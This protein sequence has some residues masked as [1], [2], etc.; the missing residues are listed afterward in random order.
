MTTYTTRQGR[1]GIY[2]TFR[3]TWVDPT[4]GWQSLVPAL[5]AEPYV[6]YANLAEET[7]KQPQPNEPWIWFTV[8]HD[9][10][11]NDS[12][13]A[14]R[15]QYEA[16]GTAILQIFTPIGN[17]LTLSDDLVNV[18]KR[19]FQAKRGINE[20][21]GI[22][23]RSVRVNEIGISERWHQTNVLVDFEYDEAV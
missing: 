16:S 23:F 11:I 13:G 8:Q 12:F 7:S 17:A 2:S 18:V 20:F 15:P 6:R 21:C 1:D 10:S 4:L 3:A 5:A 14:G 19:A 9:D 22:V